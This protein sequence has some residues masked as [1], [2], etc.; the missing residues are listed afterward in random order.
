MFVIFAVVKELEQIIGPLEG[1]LLV[2][3]AYFERVLHSDAAPMDGIMR[4]VSSTHGKR[5]RPKL[6]LLCSKL[7]GEVNERTLRAATVVEVLHNASLIHDDVVD[8]SDM[9]RGR[10]SVKARFGNVPAVLAG[11]YLLA[12]A[13]LLLSQP[14]DHDLLH[15][16]VQSAA[17]MT[18][19]ELLQSSPVETPYHDVA[20]YLEIIS[21]KTAGLIRSSCVCGALAVHAPD[22]ALPLVADFGTNLGIVF[23]M[24]DDILDDDDPTATQLAKELLPNYENKTLAALESLSPYTTNG[25]AFAALKDLVLFC[26]HRDQ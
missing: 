7:F 25:T 14:G 4:Y 18:E 16:I 1:D 8:G 6:T 11:D 2:F 13:M 15:E 21:R 5:L 22:E 3:E 26:A 23:Q 17:A 12:K 20:T 24:R 9:R 19:G 10:A